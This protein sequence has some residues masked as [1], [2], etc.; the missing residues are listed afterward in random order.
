[1]TFGLART[2]CDLQAILI[3]AVTALV[4]YGFPFYRCHLRF[5]RRLIAQ[6]TTPGR[7]L[8]LTAMLAVTLIAE[9][10]YVP[11]TSIADIWHNVRDYK[12]RKR[13]PTA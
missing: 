9:F 1:M 13:S 12:S 3:L 7:T 10:W 4:L 11:Q 5:Y 8:A 6:D 2:L